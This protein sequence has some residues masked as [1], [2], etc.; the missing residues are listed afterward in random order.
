[1]IIFQQKWKE[2]WRENLRDCQF[3]S[4]KITQAD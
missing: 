1:M 3:H 2:R 4:Y